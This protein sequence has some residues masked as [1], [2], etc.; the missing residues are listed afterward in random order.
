MPSEGRA[1]IRSALLTAGSLSLVLLIA[2]TGNTPKPGAGSS[3]PT[4]VPSVTNSPAIESYRCRHGVCSRLVLPSNT[5]VAGLS[6]EGRIIVTNTTG[7]MIRLG[8]CI[9]P[10]QVGLSNDE[11]KPDVAWQLCLQSFTFPIGESTWSVGVDANYASCGPG[12]P[13]PPHCIKGIGP[14]L[15]PG[16][17]R[18]ILYE[19]GEAIPVPAPIDVRVT[20]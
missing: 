16:A 3:H 10:F 17:Y 12:P 11:I 8:G 19:S 5:I 18:A 4:P 1:R 9:S 2:C 20:S 7:H 15:P 14:P 13:P 6:M